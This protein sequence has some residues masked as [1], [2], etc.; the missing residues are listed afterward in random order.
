MDLKT[1]IAL[2]LFTLS[3]PAIAEGYL[4]NKILNNPKINQIH[5]RLHGIHSISKQET[6]QTKNGEIYS[7]DTDSRYHLTQY[8]IKN[9]DGVSRHHIA[10]F[11]CDG[12]ED[13]A[14]VAKDGTKYVYFSS[15][16]QSDPSDIKTWYIFPKDKEMIRPGYE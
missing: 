9:N 6:I 10:D 4:E 14:I 2:G 7:I 13:Y 12:K 8:L 5:P 3:S 11:D 1:K 16:G 15:E